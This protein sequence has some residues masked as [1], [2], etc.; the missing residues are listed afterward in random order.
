[1]LIV[2]VLK[3]RK[4]SCI[5]AETFII[6]TSSVSFLLQIYQQL[7]VQFELIERWFA[8]QTFNIFSSKLVLLVKLLGHWKA[9]ILFYQ[10]WNLY[11]TCLQTLAN[12]FDIIFSKLYFPKIITS[13]Y[14]S[15][16]HKSLFIFASIFVVFANLFDFYNV[17]PSP[18]VIFR[19]LR[20]TTVWK[21][22]IKKIIYRNYTNTRRTIVGQLKNPYC[23]R[24]IVRFSYCYEVLL[25]F[26]NFS[27][28]G[29]L[30]IQK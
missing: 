21:M 26:G 19:Y 9:H 16:T 4:L 10:C 25:I 2:T 1:M 23:P 15:V 7:G 28:F 20:L 12:L 11:L 8:N 30:Q 6:I 13:F 17:F 29:C 24:T 27:H 14:V 3:K 5:V 18:D 22:A